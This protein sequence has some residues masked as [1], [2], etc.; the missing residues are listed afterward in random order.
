MSKLIKILRRIIISIFAS[1]KPVSILQQEDIS[2]KIP[3]PTAEVK[4]EKWFQREND[5][6]REFAYRPTPVYSSNFSAVDS[7]GNPMI[8]GYMQADGSVT[9]NQ[10]I[11]QME[12]EELLEDDVSTHQTHKEYLNKKRLE[13]S[14]SADYAIGIDPY[15]NDEKSISKITITKK[16]NNV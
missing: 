3:I 6:V 5:L 10:E 16:V 4:E 15:N 14:V 8:V 9:M 1:T 11:V 12:R 13:K 7:E 2:T